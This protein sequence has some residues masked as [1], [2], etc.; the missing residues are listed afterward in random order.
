VIWPT[1]ENLA[2]IKD[3]STFLTLWDG[4]VFEVHRE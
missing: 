2:L 4:V 1:V 3:R